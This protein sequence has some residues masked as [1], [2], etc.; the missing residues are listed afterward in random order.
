MSERWW[1]TQAG[2]FSPR[3]PLPG[4]LQRGN[5]RSPFSPLVPAGLD[6]RRRE[7]TYLPSAPQT[8]DSSTQ[9]GSLLPASG[10]LQLP[11]TPSWTP[12]LVS[13]VTCSKQ[14]PPPAR[15]GPQSS[16]VALRASGS[17]PHCPDAAQAR[18]LPAVAAP[19]RGTGSRR[20][21]EDMGNSRGSPRGPHPVMSAAGAGYAA[22]LRTG[23]PR[24]KES[25]ATPS[26]T[27]RPATALHRPLP[28]RSWLILGDRR[29]V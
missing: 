9:C 3:G 18:R 12:R 7:R 25:Q 8:E 26:L 22:F 19:W 1:P 16:C 24:P 5:L 4:T 10:S 21:M 20:S 29:G 23:N 11:S 13:R 15:P 17:P 28:R 2:H 27:Q 6:A 14:R